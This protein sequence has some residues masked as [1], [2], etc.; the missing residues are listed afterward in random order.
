M[1]GKA[2]CYIVE[3]HLSQFVEG[4]SIKN[5]ELIWDQMWRSSINYGRKGLVLQ[6]IS[7]IDLALWDAL[8]KVQNEPVYNLLGGKTKNKIPV[9]A[10]TARPDLAKKMV[11]SI[12]LLKIFRVFKEQKYLFR[13]VQLTET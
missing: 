4:Q 1:G 13:M 7:A 2:G 12:N 9:Y 11:L 5:I 6:V 10:T 8:G 3:T